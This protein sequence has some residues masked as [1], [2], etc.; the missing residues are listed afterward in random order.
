M[1]VGLPKP[2]AYVV[3]VSGGVDSVAL[4]HL[5]RDHPGVKLIVAHFD[6]GIREDSQEDRLHVQGLAKHYGLPFVYDEGHLGPGAS[7]AEARQAR[8]NFLRRVREV[9]N[10]QAIVTAHHQDDLLETAIINMLRGSG[11]KGLTALSSRSDLVRPLLGVSKVRIEEY[12]KDQG[13]VWREDS[14]NQ[15]EKYLRNYVR[16]RLLA[17][18]DE[19]ARTQLLQI[20]TNLQATN[21][22]L[23]GLLADELEQ[24]AEAGLLNRRWFIQLPHSMAREMMAAWLRIHDVRNFDRPTLERLVVAAKVAAPGK[25]LPIQ[26]G[27]DLQVQ[28]H[29]LALQL[30]ER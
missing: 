20:I 28:H 21:S 29:H 27:H 11:R 5:L 23:D 16:Q 24:Q 18:F 9:S 8:Y 14:T 25:V 7:E 30:A 3:A 10:A 15:D 2:G 13:L 19:P 17:K 22:E 12:A 1:D 26:A 4:L 6:H